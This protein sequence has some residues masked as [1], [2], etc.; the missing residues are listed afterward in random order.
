MPNLTTIASFQP[1]LL[2]IK[3]VIVHDPSVTD[4]TN[5]ELSKIA[6]TVVN[7]VKLSLTAVAASPG[8]AV[9][10]GTIESDF[11]QAL[12]SLPAELRQRANLTAQE[13]MKAPE[14]VKVALFGEAGRL[15]V[16]AILQNGIERVLDDLPGV[17]IR[18]SLM[19]LPSER[20]T[21][22]RSIIS[23][24]ATGL[25]IDPSAIRGTIRD[26]ESAL[27][28]APL[29]A[30]RSGVFDFEKFQDVW[31]EVHESDP[32]STLEGPLSDFESQAV[33][34]KLAVWLRRIRCVDETNPE[35]VGDDEI[36]LAGLSIDEDGDTKKIAEKYIG[37]GFSDG[38]EK[39]YS[40]WRYHWFGMRERNYWP[41]KYGVTFI[42]AEKDNGGLSTFLNDL[43]LKVKDAVY[44]A[45][46]KAAEAAGVAIGTFLGLPEVGWIIGKVLGEALAW[47]VNVLVGWLINLF[48]DDIFKPFTAWCTVPSF[49]ARW[50]YPNGTW[51]SPWSPV[52]SAHYYGFGG[53]YRLDYQWQLFS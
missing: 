7:A 29:E 13:I 38:K 46:K 51:G 27:N 21:I 49:S 4:I 3:P 50:Y 8:T 24:T 42:L 48:K 15:P 53:H 22:P 20:V 40:S 2:G 41:K 16:E 47:I 14:N 17:T 18:P 12:A 30:V 6:N 33:T 43:W 32:F 11:Q 45:I 10:A 34:D 31:G 52:F 9:R 39:Y 35:W 28:E 26:F 23:T 44:K 25:I 19:G 1:S 36:G 37:S 5:S